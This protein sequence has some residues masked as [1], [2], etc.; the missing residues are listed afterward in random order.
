MSTARPTSLALVVNL[1]I[2]GGG[3]IAIGSEA[4]GVLIATLFTLTANFAIVS[5]FLLPDEVSPTW[6]GLSIGLAIGTYLGA[7]VRYAQ[8]VRDQR[9]QAAAKLRRAILTDVRA[10]LSAGCADDAWRA[11]QPLMEQAERDLVVAYR[12]A[13][14]L[15]ARE[16]VR[17]ALRA[18]QRVRRLDRHRVYG[19]QI[20]QNE[21]VLR[22]AERLSAGD[23]QL[24]PAET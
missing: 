12:V 1:V 14:V 10:A 19:Q 3:L 13:Q 23:E 4:L 24:D 5:S 20:R 9:K 16:D 2:P 7:Q 11:I 21:R 15:T 6:R 22:G 17:G 8:T 18:W